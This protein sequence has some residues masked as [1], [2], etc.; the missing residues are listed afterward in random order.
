MNFVLVPLGIM[1]VAMT[2]L[3]MVVCLVAAAYGIV[4]IKDF[5]K[6]GKS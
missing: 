3:L 6:R 5:Y 1:L 2:L 4:L